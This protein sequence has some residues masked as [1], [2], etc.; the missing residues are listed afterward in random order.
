MEPNFKELHIY[1]ASSH[2]PIHDFL[3]SLPKYVSSEYFP[4]VPLG[5][6]QNGIHCED[7]QS[8]SFSN[9]IFDI[10]ISEDVMEHLRYPGSALREIHRVLKKGGYYVFTVP[11]YGRKTVVRVDTATNEDVHILPPLYH[12]DPLRNEGVLAYNDF[13]LDIVDLCIE[14]GFEA[15]LIEFEA[16]K[17]TWLS[18]DVIVAKKPRD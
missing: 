6:V 16:Q 10:V 11:I 7:L 4:D 12:G 13:G 8:L 17:P 3:S 18:G 14:H 15:Q 2:G 5:S 9:S 1:N